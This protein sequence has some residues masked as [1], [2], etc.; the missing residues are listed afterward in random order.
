MTSP[1]EAATTLERLDRGSD[2]EASFFRADVP[3]GWQQGRG[4]FGGLVLGMLLRA[5]EHHEGDARRTARTL[6]GDLAGPVLPGPAEIAVETLRRGS[7]QSNLRATLRQQGQ[8]LASATAVLSAPRRKRDD[9]GQERTLVLPPPAFAATPSDA[10]VVAL[11]PPLAPV[12]TPHF[13]YRPTGPL[14]FSAGR[15]AIAEGFVRERI[16]PT[17]L[18]APMLVGLLDAYW[19]AVLAVV[20]NPIAVATISF[21]AE[22]LVDPRTLDPTAPL[23]YRARAVADRDGFIVEFRELHGPS[24]VVAMNQQTFAVLA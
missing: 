18:D 14:P 5:M 8:V 7:N 24:G 12:F 11:A 21:Q 4:A 3:D 6:N 13:E 9:A 15:D 2:A 22:F 23:G 17:V 10:P 16:A 20:S 19:P 1:F